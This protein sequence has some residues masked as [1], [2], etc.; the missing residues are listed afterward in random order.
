VARAGGAAHIQRAGQGVCDGRR[1]PGAAAGAAKLA[2]R[3]CSARRLT[4]APQAL[5]FAS[6]GTAS[7]SEHVRVFAARNL[8][9]ALR[10]SVSAYGD[11]VLPALADLV[12]D[13]ST[14][15]AAAALAALA[16]AAAAPA[17]VAPILEVLKRLSAL[18][19]ASSATVRLRVCELA[20]R[21]A[22]VSPEAAA[23]V[24][25]AGLLNTLLSELDLGST[26]CADLLAALAALES[27][28]QLAES[29]AA[30]AGLGAS[31][32]GVLARLT[33][34]A[35]PESVQEPLLRAR[36]LVVCGRIA[37]ELAARNEEPP[38]TV[39]H[40]IAAG[41]NC[42]SG[43]HEVM[44]AAVDAVG[45]VGESAEGAEL[46]TRPG[47]GPLQQLVP[48]V[49]TGGSGALGSGAAQ[50]AAHALATVAGADRAPE[51][52]LLS[53]AAEVRA[54]IT[55]ACLHTAGAEAA[56]TRAQTSLRAAVQDALEHT[57]GTPTLAEVLWAAVRRRG[58]AFVE[59]RVAAYRLASGLGRRAWAANDI[60]AH[61][62][63]LD[64]LLDARGESGHRACI[65]RHA[66]VCTLARTLQ[67]S[68][69]DA[70]TA[71]GRRLAAAA[72]AG[73]FGLARREEPTPQ[74]ALLS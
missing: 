74:V 2:K 1:R 39:M 31:A 72:S 3:A 32:L 64:S 35:G 68:P 18:P 27:L 25:A 36:A 12:C 61:A 56:H 51:L 71:I 63:L 15:V 13:A 34:L 9:R 73:P 45:A 21:I 5:S 47:H 52:G 10:L 69:D 55:L 57:P 22:Q 20:A 65:W 38:D 4:Q 17:G 40:A 19:R 23:A 44:S 49:F 41:L 58:Q 14:S 62:A 54:L 28:S 29:P 59:D 8:G 50:A 16:D 66:A 24:A 30:A 70:S 48:L 37:G 11:A 33:A 6:A 67:A 43:P 26:P 53:A 42:A 46:V 60:C 7:P